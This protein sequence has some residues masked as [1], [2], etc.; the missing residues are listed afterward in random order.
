MFASVDL[1]HDQIWRI[2]T[3]GGPGVGSR[4]SRL[5]VELAASPCK[6]NE[7]QGY[8]GNASGDGTSLMVKTAASGAA[9]RGYEVMRPAIRPSP[10]WPQILAG[11]AGKIICY[12]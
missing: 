6:R 5:H 2:T 7:R 11:A 9:Y 10:V 3:I 8:N 12:N 4:A 1:Q